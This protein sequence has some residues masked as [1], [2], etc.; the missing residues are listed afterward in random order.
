MNSADVEGI[1]SVVVNSLFVVYSLFV[2][3]TV[4]CVCVCVCVC[5]HATTLIF[6]DNALF[7]LIR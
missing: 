2:V 1:D 7:W 5:V 4:V 6:G 3:A